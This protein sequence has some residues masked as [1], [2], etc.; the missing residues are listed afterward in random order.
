MTEAWYLYIIECKT[1]E[2]Y[3]GI[4]QDVV[5]RVAEHNK[6]SACRYTKFRGPVRLVYSEVCVDYSAARK[7]EKQV[8]DF[9]RSKKL[10]LMRDFSPQ[11][12]GFE[13]QIL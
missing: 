11:K 3:T 6:G 2:F 12:A 13:V 7:R 1:G 9:S 5:E 4:A 8:K 10:S